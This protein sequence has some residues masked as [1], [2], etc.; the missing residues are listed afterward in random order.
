MYG[1]QFSGRERRAFKLFMK[2]EL[3]SEY[4]SLGDWVRARRRALQLTQKALAKRVNITEV[5]LQKIEAGDRQPGVGTPEDP[6]TAERLAQALDLS[7]DDQK[8]FAR[9]SRSEVPVSHLPSPSQLAGAA[10][11]PPLHEDLQRPERKGEA[12]REENKTSLIPNLPD[13]RTEHNPKPL[14]EAV[15]LRRMAVALLIF[16]VTA[17][18]IWVWSLRPPDPVPVAILTHYWHPQ[19]QDNLLTATAAVQQQAKSDG[20]QETQELEGYLYMTQQPDTVALVRYFHAARRDYALASTS[21]S[22][23]L[24]TGQGYQRQGP[25]GY[26]YSTKQPGTVPLQLFFHSG[27]GDYFV[28]ATTGGQQAAVR[29][30][31]QLVGTEGFVFFPNQKLAIGESG[32]RIT[33]ACDLSVLSNFRGPSKGVLRSGER[34]YELGHFEQRSYGYAQGENYQAIGWVETRW[35]HEPSLVNWMIRMLRNY[36]VCRTS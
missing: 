1:I 34:F 9:C 12:S 22:Q 27:R 35:L 7:A 31:Y 14:L 5:Y 32:W 15:S 16:S 21:Q 11:S 19:W 13:P 30:G 36:Y 26:L 18:G 29:A 17:V 6:G 33:Y 2:D 23:Q 20:Y 4:M 8:L 28:T 10:P 25:E 3:M 24:L